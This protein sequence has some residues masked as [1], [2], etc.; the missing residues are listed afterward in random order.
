M[1]RRARANRRCKS[2]KLANRRTERLATLSDAGGRL[3]AL[4]ITLRL[5]KRLGFL[6]NGGYE[7]LCGGVDEIGRMLGGWLKYEC[8]P[9]PRRNRGG[10]SKLRGH[11]GKRTAALPGWRDPSGRSCAPRPDPRVD[12][13]FVQISAG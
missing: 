7:R 4:R 13:F 6:S 12:E 5:S 3:D 8:G 1:S 9:K 11:H 10:M 2:S